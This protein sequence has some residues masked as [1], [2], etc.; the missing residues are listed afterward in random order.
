MRAHARDRMVVHLEG[1]ML[2]LSTK[3]VFSAIT[4]RSMLIPRSGLIARSGL[5]DRTWPNN[6]SGLMARSGWL[7][8]A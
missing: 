5:I 6:R 7:V 1:S 2:R 4:A 3:H 8:I